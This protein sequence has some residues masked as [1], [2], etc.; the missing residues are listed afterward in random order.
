MVVADHVASNGV[1]HVIDRV[2]YPIPTLN[3]AQYLTRDS[4]YFST[5]LDAVQV[6]GLTD[7]FAGQ[8]SS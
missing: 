7:L 4:T 3:I 1:I 5:L 8:N 6:A 2:M